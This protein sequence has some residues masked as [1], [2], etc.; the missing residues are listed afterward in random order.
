MCW[1]SKGKKHLVVAA[2]L[3][4]PSSLHSSRS[5][6]S[7]EDAIC[8]LQGVVDPEA[9]RK[10]IGAGFIRVFDDF[11]KGL[12]QKHGVK[13]RFV[14]QVSLPVPPAAQL[15]PLQLWLGHPDTRAAVV[16]AVL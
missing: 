15:T 1:L 2:S 4:S 5:R 16:P 3:L 6:S 14:V 8:S 7:A 9:K 13:P 10:K 11:A 12:E